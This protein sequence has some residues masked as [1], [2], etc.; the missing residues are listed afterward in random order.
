M[1]IKKTITSIFMVPTLNIP[2]NSLKD[3]NFINGYIKDL[4]KDVQYEDAIY[5]LF[6]P[7]NIDKFRTFLENEYERTKD[8]IEDYD[9]EDGYVVVVYLL[10]KKLKEDFSL[11]KIGA[12]SKT[13]K[14]FQEC[15]PKT[16]RISKSEGNKKLTYADEISLQYRV[17]N[18]TKDLVEFWEEKLNVNFDSDQEVWNEFDEDTET[19]N[20]NKI[21]TPVHGK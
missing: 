14:E 11:V 7:K 20:I 18:K 6:K 8:I 17:F 5:L 9:Y 13:S 19:L 3:N 10:N 4:G 1:E 15:F 2:K 16:I 21:K 12:Y